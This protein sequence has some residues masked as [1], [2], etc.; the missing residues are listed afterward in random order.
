MKLLN[1]SLAA[2][3]ML[4]LASCA[5]TP[6][7][8]DLKMR[9]EKPYH[10]VFR[11]HL[12]DL[13]TLT[14]FVPKNETLDTWTSM[15]SIQF[16]KGVKI[17]PKVALEKLSKL[18][19]DNCGD[20]F[21]SKIIDE[22]KTSITFEWK[23]EDCKQLYYMKPA[24]RRV[25]IENCSVNY[26]T[27]LIYSGAQDRI[28]PKCEKIATEYEVARI[29]KGNDGLQRVAYTTKGKTLDP[30]ERDNWLKAIK[31]LYVKKDGKKISIEPN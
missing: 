27:G 23:V 1:Y 10:V 29:L 8:I 4:M 22:D 26:F 13:G 2:V 18:A 12:G 16:I 28:T 14:E 30:E 25:S 21:S 24:L 15:I 31:D 5:T 3:I 17:S 6:E 7:Y 11:E 19:K 9:T 20:K